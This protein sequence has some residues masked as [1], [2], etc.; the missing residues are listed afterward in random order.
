M[1]LDN[2]SINAHVTAEI[3]LKSTI[4]CIYLRSPLLLLLQMLE[5][6]FNNFREMGRASGK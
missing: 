4:M 6:K 1:T 2:N 5:I 3:E